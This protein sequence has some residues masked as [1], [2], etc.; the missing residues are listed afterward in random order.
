MR[1]KH[2]QGCVLFSGFLALKPNNV[3]LKGLKTYREKAF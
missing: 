1:R 3:T 2:Q